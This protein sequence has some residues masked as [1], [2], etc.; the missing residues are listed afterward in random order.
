ML[1]NSEI[2]DRMGRVI[3]TGNRNRG[4]FRRKYNKAWGFFERFNKKLI[5]FKNLNIHRHF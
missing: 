3:S 5:S 1:Q 2:F 4:D